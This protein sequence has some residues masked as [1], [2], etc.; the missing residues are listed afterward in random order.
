MLTYYFKL[1]QK[2]AAAKKAISDAE[3][4]KH[5]KPGNNRGNARSNRN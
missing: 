3:A 2:K 4:A 5:N 1:D